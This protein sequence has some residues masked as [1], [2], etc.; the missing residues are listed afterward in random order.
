MLKHQGQLPPTVKASL[1][2]VLKQGLALDPAERFQSDGDWLDALNGCFNL[3]KA[4]PMR[5]PA[6][7]RWLLRQL[8]R[9]ETLF[10]RGLE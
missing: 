8:G 7:N 2:R 9:L 3:L 1:D 6:A 5:M 10:S 4:K